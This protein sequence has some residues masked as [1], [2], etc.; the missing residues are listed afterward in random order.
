[1]TASDFVKALSSRQSKEHAEKN[2]RYFR[3]DTNPK[4]KF[5]G[6]RMKIIFDT[7]K[8]F[9][10]LPIK[11]IEK[12]LK[13]PYY[14]VRMG[15]VS[16][17]DFRARNK[18]ITVAEQKALFDLYINR[19][20]KIDNWDLVDRSAPYVVGA[21][22]KDKSREILYSLAQST[23]VWERRTAIVSTYYFIR[24]GD[25][26]DTFRIAEILVNDQH[27]LIHKAVGSWVRHAGG[28]D[29]NRLIKFLDKHAS[30]MPPDML[31]YAIEKLN[32]REKEKYKGK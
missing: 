2:S 19:H 25:V 7:A 6:V 10:Q 8:E 31:S 18:K 3:S 16:I 26:D 17:M 30:T 27:D 12:L 9:Q 15:A 24:S 5:L 4:N 11:E 20:D 28:K 21:Y 13:S 1:M 14:E 32:T 29:K 23:N 22:L